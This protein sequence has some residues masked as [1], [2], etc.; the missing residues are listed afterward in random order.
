M[1]AQCR[2]YKCTVERKGFRRELDSWRHKLINCVGFESI[3]EGIYGPLLLRDLNI[4]DDCEPEELDDWAVEAGCSFCGLLINDHVPVAAASPSQGPSL[5]DSSLSAH[6]F[7]HAV[8]HKKELASGGDPNIPLVAQEL[9]RRM[10]RQFAIEYVSKT[11]FT[12][13]TST[14]TGSQRSD[15]DTPLDLTV[16]RNQENQEEEPTPAN[17]V[18]DLSKRSSARSP[19][20]PQ[21]LR[22]PVAHGYRRILRLAHQQ[23]RQ[24]LAYRDAHRRLVPPPDPLCGHLVAKQQKDTSSPPP[25]FPF[26]DCG[27]HSAAGAS[28]QQTDWKTP[29]GPGCCCVQR[30]RLPPVCY[31]LHCLPAPT[32]TPSPA[33]TPTPS[34]A[35]TP[36]PQPQPRSHPNPRSC[37]SCCP[38]YTY[39]APVRPTAQ[40]GGGSECPVLKRERSRSRSPPPL[41]P[42]PSD[43]DGKEEDKPPSLLQEEEEEEEGCSGEQ[44]DLVERFSDKL[45]TIRSQEKDPPLSSALA[46]HNL[47]NDPHL[48]TSANQH[49]AESQAD[50]HLSEIITTV[51]NTGGGS[52]YSLNDLLHRHDNNESRPPRTRSRRRQEALAA[53]MT[54]P[55]QPSTR[56][57]T[58]LIK[59]E[60]ARLNQSLCRRRP[61]LGKN[62]S[63]SATPSSTCSSPE[64]TPFIPE[65][66]LVTA[67]VEGEMERV[68]E[69]EMERVKEGEMER[70]KG[71]EM[72][73]VKEGEMERVTEEA[74]PVRVTKD[75]V[76]V[77][78]E[79]K[80]KPPVLSSTQQ[81]HPQED[82]HKP[83]SWKVTCQESNRRDL[84]EKK[85]REEVKPGSTG[86]ACDHGSGLP[87]RSNEEEETPETAG[88]SKDSSRVSAR[89]S[90]SS[91]C[92]TRRG[93]RSQPGSSKVVERSSEAGRSGRRNIV[94]PQRFSSY[95]TEPRKMYFAACFSE[96]IFS[97]QRTP[98]DRPALNAPTTN[99]TDSPSL[100][101]DTA[102]GSGEAREEELLLASTPEVVSRERR[103]GRGCGS[104]AGGQSSDSESQRRGQVIPVTAASSEQQSPPKHRSQNRANVRLSAARPYVRL[105]SAPAQPQGQDPDSQSQPE[106]PQTAS[107][108]EGEVPTEQPQYTSPIKLMFVSAVV[109]EEGVRYTLKAAAPGSSWYGQETFDPCEE[110]SWAGTPEKTPEKTHNPPK[111]KSP[112]QT[113][114]PPKTRSPPKDTV[115]SSPKLCGARGGEG[116]SPPK[117][118]PGSLNGDGPPPIRET[119]P[120]KR[121]PGR[122]K[123]LGPQLEKRAKRPIGRPPK[124][125]GVELSCGSRQG[126]Q[127]RSSG[128]GCSTGEGSSAV[129]GCQ[130]TDPANRN[131]KITVVYGRSHRTK[132]T[133]SEEAACLQA[134][135]KLM[136]LNFVRPVKERRFASNSSSNIKCQKL[137]CAAAM[138]RPGR[139]AKV[140]ISGISVTVTTVSPRQRKIHMNRDTARKSPEMLCRRKALLPE[141]QPS[142]EPRKIGSTPTSE[143]A[144]QMQTERTTKSRDGERER[145]IQTPP[146]LAVRHSVRVRKPSVYLLHS[147]ATSTS[148]SLSHSTA[149]LRRSRQLLINR[150]SSKGSQRRRKEEEGGRR[151][152]HPRAGGAALWEGG[153]EDHVAGVSV[154]SIFPACSSEA[155]RWWPVSSDQD[156]LN[157]E[158]ARRI[159]LISHSWVSSATAHTTRMGTTMSAKQR[160]NDDDSSPSWKPEV[161][162]AVR[163]LFD[164]RCSVERL[165]SWFM[166]TTETQSLGIVK[167]TSSR[168]P[169]ELLHYP[170]AASRG[171][172]FPSPQTARL[173]KHIKKFAKAV[174]KSPAQL[175]LAQERLQRGNE[176]NAR[177]RLF[178][179][180][181]A[182]GGLRIRAPWR[183]VRALGMYRTTLLRVREKFLT[184]TLRAKRPNRLRYSQAVWR[185][186]PVEVGSSPGQVRPS[187]H[188]R[189]ELTC[190]PHHHRLPASSETSQ[191]R[192]PVH[193]TDQLTG[194]T[195]QQCLSSK[196]WSPE[197]L[198][199][200]CVFL[201]KINSPDTESTAEEEWDVCTVNLDDAYC[202]DGTRQEERRDGE[203]RAGKTERRKRRV[204]WKESSGSAQEVQEHNRVRAGKRRGKRN[205]SGN[206]TS[207]SPIPPPAKVMRKSRGRGL[208]G[209]WWHDFILGT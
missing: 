207:Q 121:R 30:C 143:D 130:E 158:L 54:L 72:E 133:V 168:N 115:S 49:I 119:T 25:S 100:A 203:G 44:Q 65:P 197:T 96:R 134:T 165:A 175:R 84:S 70:V 151:R 79:M 171:S 9:M 187:A 178:T 177:R 58:V 5:S 56:R 140:K 67:E 34:P 149:L 95:V 74:G 123:K 17:S 18:L 176:L 39:L 31:C 118:S 63:R 86:S 7:L 142:K 180:R 10:V 50:A 131:L 19:T 141:P 66:T 1:A 144:T 116:G 89:S 8:F 190:S 2:S 106:S 12:T 164:R 83:D 159:R 99:H 33:P 108:P 94:P 183:K 42:I 13:S 137:Q 90:P 138:R 15:L 36:T 160:L 124:Q 199:E 191:P 21:S 157:Q 208:T 62:K 112:L 82:K 155:L 26:T 136:D 185:R 76:S 3:L 98:K 152:G 196:A 161:G 170:R 45:K 193:L 52:D 51:L 29:A 32:P 64:P 189:E 148:R 172:V 186:R 204:P 163:M 85:R 135:V 4:F 47:E 173:R 55:D 11:H 73:R 75:R 78:E 87:E 117:R 156:S 205:N 37:T 61:S 80:D 77:K 104:T 150:A 97:A 35:P 166:Q 60:L 120:P 41:S 40:G 48:T 146:L 59:R 182:P 20:F 27:S 91:P 6:R 69:R 109:G 145:Q 107:R 154:D 14:A 102:E 198:K 23:H 174:P 202:P 16:T 113:K 28:H 43:M 169:Y 188:P 125:R 68:K 195:K 139:P 200:C 38:E 167:K 128:L 209:P 57:Q 194:L 126:G 179:A 122:P 71:G 147:V 114:S 192:S 181:P 22:L 153:E 46:N 111:T 53:M 101:T 24:S 162:S 184:R 92:R 110:S 88:C 127:D 129:P 103:G 105:R 93:R 201:K 81:S 206:A 132:R